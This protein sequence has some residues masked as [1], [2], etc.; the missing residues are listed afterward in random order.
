MANYLE[1][2]REGMNPK[3]AKLLQ[4]MFEIPQSD[5]VIA[6]TLGVEEDYLS[7]WAEEAGFQEAYDKYWIFYLMETCILLAS[8]SMEAVSRQVDRESKYSRKDLERDICENIEIL[9]IRQGDIVNI[10]DIT[11]IMDETTLKP[12]R[13]CLCNPGKMLSILKQ[14]AE[15]LDIGTPELYELP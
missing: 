4:I 1:N 6:R 2:A 5:K 11:M 14:I 13:P 8:T 10:N 12:Q 3:K 9:E 7:V 15:E